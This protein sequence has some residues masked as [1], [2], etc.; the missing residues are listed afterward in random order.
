MLRAL[1]NVID[2]DFGTS[3]VACNFVKDLSIDKRSGA[4]KFRLEL[5]TP[6]CPVKDEFKRQCQAF[7]GALDWVSTVEVEIDAQSPQAAMPDENRPP[8]LKHVAHIIAVSSC[9]GGKSSA[10]QYPIILRTKMTEVRERTIRPCLSRETNIFAVLF[11]GQWPSSFRPTLGSLSP[12][13]G[14]ISIQTLLLQIIQAVFQCPRSVLK[15]L[16]KA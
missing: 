1:E 3:I 2:P 4:V 7:V 11:G 12:N 6:A 10:L 16:D 14:N 8:G 13:A 9:K 5:T 15:F